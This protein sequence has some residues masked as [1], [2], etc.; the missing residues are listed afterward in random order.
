MPARLTLQLKKRGELKIGNYADIVV[1]D[2][3]YTIRAN[4]TYEQPHQLATGVSDVFVNG[5]QGIE[6][7]RPHRRK[8]RPRRLRPRL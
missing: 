1:F 6:N 7:R 8:T 5:T 2:P 3:A 4:S